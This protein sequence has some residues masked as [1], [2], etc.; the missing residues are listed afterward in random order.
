MARAGKGRLRASG[1]SGWSKEEYGV[2]GARRHGE[3]EEI[4]AAGAHGR[5]GWR[6]DEAESTM[7]YELVLR[8][9]D[10]VDG[11][12]CGRGAGPRAEEA[13]VEGVEEVSG[14]SLEASARWAER[15]AAGESRGEGGGRKEGSRA[16]CAGEEGPLLRVGE[17]ARE[18]MAAEKMIGVG[19]QNCQ[20]QGESTPIYRKWLGLG[21]LSGP[22]GLGFKWAWPETCNRAALNIF[23]KKARANFV[24][25]QNRVN[26]S[27]DERTIERLIRPRV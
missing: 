4:P 14:C 21:F 25:M 10:A 23:R 5:R 1:R 22:N 15:V 20:V 2:Q 27:S 19:V 9:A 16:P 13:G 24:G 6:G 12:W 8:A 17:E 7:K 26:E 18:A 11:A 3:G